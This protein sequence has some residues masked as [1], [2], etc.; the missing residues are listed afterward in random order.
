YVAA[1]RNRT[2]A[3]RTQYGSE[4]ERTVRHA[5]S[6]HAAE[7]ELVK[8]QERVDNLD[9][10]PLLAEQRELYDQQWHDLQE[11]FVEDPGGAV[12]HADSLVMDVMRTRGYPVANFEQRAA[13]LSVHH[14][15]FVRNYRASRDVAE[16]HRR[17]A[18]TTEELRRA[19]VY[20]HELFEDLL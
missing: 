8:R 2:S 3:L 16:R 6:R 11:L 17:G 7:S 20:Y 5:T 18:A 4:Y 13:D 12:N 15:R 10:R 1:R 9:I 19:M 14:A